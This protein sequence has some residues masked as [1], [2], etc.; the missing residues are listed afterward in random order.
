MTEDEKFMKAALSQARLAARDGDVPV[1]AVI[2]RDGVIIARARNE[3]EKKRNALCHAELTAISRACK[4]LG[5][6]RLTNCVLYVTLEPCPMCAAA[7]RE[8]RVARVVYGAPAV[9]QDGRRSP[10]TAP[11]PEVE[12]GVRET[13]CAALV[14]DFCRSLRKAPKLSNN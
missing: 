3:R 7:I 9:Y 11:A 14:K 1:G 6:W 12:G 13:E 2:V 4:R 8:A 5:G 10:Q